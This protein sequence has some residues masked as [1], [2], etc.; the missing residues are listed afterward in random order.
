MYICVCTYICI[1]V[2][3]RRSARV[4][5]ALLDARGRGALDRAAPGLITVISSLG[6]REHNLFVS[7]KRVHFI[8]VDKLSNTC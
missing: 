1:Y 5:R 2:I 3:H 7:M 6:L 8:A 4:L